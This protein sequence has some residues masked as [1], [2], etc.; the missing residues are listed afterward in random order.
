MA[1]KIKIADPCHED[2]NNMTPAEKGKFCGACSKEVIDFTNKSPNRI[3][4]Y[5][6]KHR[7][8]NICG[9]FSKEQLNV[10]F[11]NS[12]PPVW[13]FGAYMAAI[14]LSALTYQTGQT[15]DTKKP[16]AIQQRDS[17]RA[18]IN[19]VSNPPRYSVQETVANATVKGKVK[20]QS[21]TK[22]SFKNLNITGTLV[23]SN[24]NQPLAG[25]SI[26][27]VD[28]DNYPID[29]IMAMTDEEGK[30]TYK[31]DK[32]HKDKF[33]RTTYLGYQSKLIPVSAYFESKKSVDI[34]IE[35]NQIIHDIMGEIDLQP[36]LLQ[37]LKNTVR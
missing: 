33:L 9:R 27:L 10:S 3:Y 7:G 20:M 31:I 28:S 34:M 17:N 29:C 26:S 4:N 24:T 13:K 6:D 18:D 15:Q 37:K 23:D 1:Y 2:W 19:S 21:N 35:M 32:I 14:G 5:L 22:I 12:R 8:Q 36:S 25:V 30:F 11:T 16:P